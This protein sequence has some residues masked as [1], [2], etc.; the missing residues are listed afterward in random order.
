VASVGG[1]FNFSF[2][3]S[4]IKEL[5]M[6][7]GDVKDRDLKTEKSSP[8]NVEKE[9]YLFTGIMMIWCLLLMVVYAVVYL[10]IYLQT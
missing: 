9:S 3:Q 8:I 5:T 6:L 2:C 1:A 10:L 4:V 7:Q